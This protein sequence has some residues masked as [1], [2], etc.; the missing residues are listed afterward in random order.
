MSMFMVFMLI[1]VL[2]VYLDYNKVSFIGV[3]VYSISHS[4]THNIS[5]FTQKLNA[6]FY[7]T[8]DY[9]ERAQADDRFRQHIERK[10]D[11]A[12]IKLLSRV[13]NN[14]KQKQKEL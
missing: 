14:V 3:P 13:C 6:P 5:R 4:T 11:F 7:A 2:W 8:H 9:I 10:M 12:Y 1:V